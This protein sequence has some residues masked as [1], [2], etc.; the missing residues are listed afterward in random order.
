MSGHMDDTPRPVATS[1]D[2][3]F[4]L[5]VEAALQVYAEAGLPRTPRTVQRYCSN[6]H[7]DCRLRETRFGE[8]YMISPESLEKHI[9]YVKEVTGATGHVSSRPVGT[10]RS[11]EDGHNPARQESY[12]D[13]LSRQVEDSR[14]VTQLE[15]EVRFLRDQVGVKDGQ[16]KELTERARETNHLIAGLQKMLSPLLNVP[17]RLGLGRPPVVTEGSDLSGTEDS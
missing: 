3:T 15:G 4:T 14:Y 10:S 8:K 11:I 13:D 12:T 17:N 7:L 9:A 2:E 16:I 6:A 1:N 5:S